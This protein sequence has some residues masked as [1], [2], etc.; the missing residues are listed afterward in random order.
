MDRNLHFPVWTWS[1]TGFKQEDHPFFSF[2]GIQNSK[3][4]FTFFFDFKQVV[5]RIWSQIVGTKPDPYAARAYM[6]SAYSSNCSFALGGNWP[7]VTR[8][9]K[10]YM[11]RNLNR[12]CTLSCQ[13]W[14]FFFSL[15][16]WPN[17][18]LISAIGGT[19]RIFL[20]TLCC[21]V[22]QTLGRVAPE[23]DI[24]RMLYRLS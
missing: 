16:F 8:P 1:R 4:T 22:I 12:F 7:P 23:W 13:R 14:F 10:Y 18:S 20:T 15:P 9:Y 21:C 19:A 17:S 24:W 6:L 2:I 11:I 5:S 3:W